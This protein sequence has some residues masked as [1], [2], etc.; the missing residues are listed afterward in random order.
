M[1]S[2]AEGLRRDIVMDIRLLRTEM[3]RSRNVI[4]SLAE[5]VV[6]KRA[7]KEVSQNK[8]EAHS[9][10][11]GAFVWRRRIPS[12]DGAFVLE[13]AHSFG[14]EAFF[15]WMAHSSGRRRIPLGDGA[16]PLEMTHSSA[17]RRIPHGDGAFLLETANLSERRDMQLL[18]SRLD[19]QRHASLLAL[20]VLAGWQHSDDGRTNAQ[21]S[22]P[23]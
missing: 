2:L 18:H 9:S 12:G 6:G 23:R 8:L 22:C 5:M 7:S 14:D 13:T 15:L 17:K 11:D 1:V 4:S 21:G 3:G 10:G 16:Y 20:L 19:R